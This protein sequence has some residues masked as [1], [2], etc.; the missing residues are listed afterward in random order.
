MKSQRIEAL[1]QL[2]WTI[3][4][5]S[6]EFGPYQTA[7]VEELPDAIATGKGERALAKMLYASI[8]ASLASRLEFGDDIALPPGAALPWADEQEPKHEQSFAT[9]VRVDLTTEAWQRPVLRS[10]AQGRRFISAPEFQ[11]V[12]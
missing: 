7:S 9:S 6:S 5:A 12:A 3:H 11:S 8:R 1:M 4:T 10:T 2:P